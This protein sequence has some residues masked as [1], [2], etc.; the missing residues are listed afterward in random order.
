MNSIAMA[1]AADSDEKKLANCLPF[2]N[3]MQHTSEVKGSI[4]EI[5]GKVE[6]KGPS[7]SELLDDFS[8]LT[9]KLT[10]LS[11]TI[12]NE[13]S[14]SEF[15]TVREFFVVD[16]APVDAPQTGIYTEIIGPGPYKHTVTLRVWYHLYC[17]TFR[18]PK[19]CS[20]QQLTLHFMG[21]LLHTPF[22]PIN[23]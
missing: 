17:I 18:G 15:R 16:R 20:Y 19:S 11:K 1:T 2:N 23:Q 5:L 4:S 22:V 8:V 9:A 21:T 14:E 12:A 13:R 3:I 6:K 10:T 7:Y